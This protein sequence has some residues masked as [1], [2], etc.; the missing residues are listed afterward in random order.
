MFVPLEQAVPLQTLPY[1]YNP[2]TQIL[3]YC[4]EQ[5]LQAKRAAVGMPHLIVNVCKTEAN[6]AEVEVQE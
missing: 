2:L 3:A 1:N 4:I 6:N 5:G